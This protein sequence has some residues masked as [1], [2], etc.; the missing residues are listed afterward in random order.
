MRGMP[1]EKPGAN[2]PTLKLTKRKLERR[3]NSANIHD[4]LTCN[5][6]FLLLRQDADPDAALGDAGRLDA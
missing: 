1:K 3:R 4:N 5:L 6:R 2:M